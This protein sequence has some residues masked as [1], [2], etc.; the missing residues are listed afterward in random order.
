MYR[1][2][3]QNKVIVITLAFLLTLIVGFA[4][5]SESINVNGTAKASGDFNIIFESVGTPTGK[6]SSGTAA[7]IKSDDPTYL[8]ISV[9]KLEYPTAYAVIP[10]VIKNDGDIDAYVKDIRTRGLVSTDIN[11]TFSG[12]D[13]N[14]ILESG[15]TKN[16]SIKVEWDENSTKPVDSLVFDIWIDYEQ[17]TN[18][19]AIPPKDTYDLGDEICLGSECF[20]VMKDDGTNVT[21]MAKYNLLVGQNYDSSNSTYTPIALD[22]GGYGLQN[23]EARG[24]VSGEKISTGVIKFSETNYWKGET[25]SKP[26]PK[27]GTSY[28]ADVFDENSNLYKIIKNYENYLRQNQGR[29][30]IEAEPAAYID[31]V[32]LGCNPKTFKCINNTLEWVYSTSY[33]V[34]SAVDNELMWNVDS[35]GSFYKSKY[36]NILYNGVRPVIKILKSEI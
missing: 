7:S 21:A 11:V 15:K 33:W 25:T 32:D 26:L 14:E 9:P 1:I 3:R 36:S 35:L 23:E 28:P 16:I 4:I 13:K 19:V 5:F 2:S 18:Q 31:L 24:Y 29:Q 8:N 20:Y 12:I 6:G 27:Y 34:A 22:T 17:V 30:S 10:V